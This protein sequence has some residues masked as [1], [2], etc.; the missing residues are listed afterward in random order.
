[1]P[2]WLPVFHEGSAT[3]PGH[4]LLSCDDV[5][6]AGVIAELVKQAAGR[7]SIMAGGG[8]RSH[9]AAAICS[10]T[11]VW[12]LH[13]SA[14]RCVALD[15]LVRPSHAASGPYDT[16]AA[17]AAT[18]GLLPRGA[19]LSAWLKLFLSRS[20]APTDCCEPDVRTLCCVAQQPSSYKQ[21]TQQCYTD[22]HVA[23]HCHQQDQSTHSAHICC[24][25]CLRATGG[26]AAQWSSGGQ[27]CISARKHSPATLSGA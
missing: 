18:H 11:G 6:G 12:E 23:V 9:N 20:L 3:L 10:K 15:K 16:V 4:V 17:T 25:H 2:A 22:Q 14:S 24:C 7:I 26:P 21:H 8:M 13:S 1:V 19:G 5:Q 27:T